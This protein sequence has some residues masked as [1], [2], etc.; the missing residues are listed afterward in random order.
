LKERHYART[1]EG[2][3][4]VVLVSLEVLFLGAFFLPIFVHRRADVEAFVQYQKSPTPESQAGWIKER[5]IT[6]RETARIR[7][8]E[9]AQAVGNLLLIG[10]CS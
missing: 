9:A 7:N 2:N 6:E 10:V 1:D 5:M 8:V 4:L 3:T